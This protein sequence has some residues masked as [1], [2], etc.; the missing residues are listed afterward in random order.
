MVF[1]KAYRHSIGKTELIKSY[2]EKEDAELLDYLQIV[3]IGLVYSIP[4]YQERKQ[5]LEW[6]AMVWRRKQEEMTKAELNDY[7]E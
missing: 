2:M 3:D 1:P 5:K 4:N 6:C 7:L